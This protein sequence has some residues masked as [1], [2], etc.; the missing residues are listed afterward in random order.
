MY[1]AVWA[2]AGAAWAGG[3]IERAQ[4]DGARRTALVSDA[5]HWPAGL[6]LHAARDELYWCDT[7]LNKLERLLLPSNKRE[8]LLANSP[9]TPIVKPYGLAIYEDTIM[10]SEHDSG[11]VR[12]RAANGSVSVLHALPP[13]LYDLRLVSATS[14]HG[15]NA[16]SRDNGGC[17]ELCLAAGAGRVCACAPPRE[18]AG[19]ACGP[20]R[21]A[22]RL[23]TPP[24]CAADHF[25]C[26]KGRCVDSLYVCDGDVDC[27]DGSDEDVGPNGPC[28]NVTCDEDHFMQCDK[29]RCLPRSWVCDGTKDC[30]DGS[31]EAEAACARASCGAAQW[32]C[33]GSRRCLPAAWRCDAAV[34]CGPNDRSDEDDC[35]SADC[36]SNLMFKCAESGGGACVPWEYYCDGHADCADASD[37]RACA[38]PAP[39]PASAEPATTTARSPAPPA[40]ACAPPAL[41]CDNGSRCVPLALQCDGRADCADGADEADRCGEPM[42]ELAAC[43]HECHAAPGGPVCACPE[44]LRLQPDQLSCAPAHA[45]SD[46]GVCSQTCQPQKNGRHKCTCYEGYRLA[47]DGFTCKS[48]VNATPL[49]V[50]SNRHEVRAV[51]LASLTS[52]ALLSALKN[53]VALDWLGRPAAPPRLFWTDVVDDKIYSGTLHGTSLSGIEVVVE[54]GLWTVEGI[55]VDWVAENLYWVESGLHQIEVARLDGRWRRTLLSGDMDSPRAIAVD[56]RVGYLFWS[57]WDAA[58]ARIERASLAGRGRRVLV[59]VGPLGGGAWPNGIALDHLAHRLYWIDARQAARAGRVGPLGGGAWPNGIA[60]DHLAHRL[61]WIDARSDAIHTTT[62]DGTGYQEVLRGHAALSHPFAVTLFESHVYWT[63]WRSNSVVRADKWR[64]GHVAVVQRTLTQPF[65]LKVIHPSR[66]PPAASNP[67]AGNGNCSH[68]C[69]IDA[70]AARVCACPHLMRLAPDNVTCEVHEKV[71]LIARREEIRGVDWDEPALALAPAITA[72]HLRAPAHLATLAADGAVLWADTE[73][74]LAL[75]PAITAPHL[76]APAHL[77]TLAADGAVLWADTETG[78]IKRANIRG[79]AAA[80]LVEGAGDGGAGVALA[81]CARLL[82]YAAPGALLAADA[83]GR[84]AARLL[85]LRGNVTALACDPIRGQLYWAIGAGASERIETADGAGGNQR[86]L[87]RAPHVAGVSG[88]AVDADGNRL[89]WINTGTATIQYLDLDHMNVTTLALEWGSRPAAL[90]LAGARL[91]WAD[92]AGGALRSCRAPD[93]ADSRPLL[94]H[95]GDV[96]ALRVYDPA[97]EAGAGACARAACAHLCLPVARDRSV[98]RCALGYELKGDDCVGMCS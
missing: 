75:A 57:D 35:E 91:L 89:Y 51:E 7:Y 32:A 64:G 53:T 25:H 87:L 30:A 61:Y 60:L 92:A 67:C 22:P 47:D 6:A 58:A 90:A 63:D 38:S 95:A 54:Q 73:P 33:A 98:C 46:W 97:T 26:G 5:L 49:L 31:D 74:A 45:C 17:A 10:W 2:G 59:R 81:V 65:D 56:P 62:Y 68:L 28:A 48:T 24:P 86:E 13:P 42:C 44:P 82:Y 66:Q 21:P 1:W 34:D 36:D 78:E 19:A 76:R 79:G 8:T 9:T 20:P 3:R 52:R 11:L 77:A 39:S 29:N 71:I 4:M 83:R 43:S 55:A 72:P 41:A 80:T 88:L 27:P 50:F 37:E 93:C 70:P 69:L 16:C 94:Q 14:R 15:S 23:T 96:L 40:P 12:A 18:P 85:T 84:R